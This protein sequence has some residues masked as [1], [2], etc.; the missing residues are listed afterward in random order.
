M[1]QSFSISF[2]IVICIILCCQLSIIEGRRT[3]SKPRKG[4]R[5][6]GIDIG[7]FP[8]ELDNRRQGRPGQDGDVY[9][10]HRFQHYGFKTPA[11]STFSLESMLAFLA[12][13]ATLPII[14]S[15]A[16]SSMAAI[17]PT[18]TTEG[19]VKGRGRREAVQDMLNSSFN[20][21]SSSWE[22]TSRGDISRERDI[23]DIDIIHKYLKQMSPKADYNDQVMAS[24]LQCSGMLSYNN[25]CLERLACQ[26]SDS[27]SKMPSLEKDVS[28][29]IIYT[30]LNNKHIKP[31]FKE[32]IR[33]AA[34]YGRDTNGRCGSYFC[35]RN[36]FRQI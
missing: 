21:N 19:M 28:S 15:A 17:L 27:S 24:Y 9:E 12:P 36:D 1:V 13:L 26:F 31:E 20:F 6:Q 25:H 5:R 22:L 10:F 7:E 14:A 33:K 4:L 32:R 30:I 23:R 34:F 29:L 8:G 2:F 16:L 11:P 18:L 35:S 3:N